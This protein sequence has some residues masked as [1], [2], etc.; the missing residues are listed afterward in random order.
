MPSLQEKKENQGKKRKQAAELSWVRGI[1]EED[2]FKKGGTPHTGV[3]I[4]N[5][6]G[7]RF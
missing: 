6:E 7:R 2:A 1:R 3:G 5:E 4:L